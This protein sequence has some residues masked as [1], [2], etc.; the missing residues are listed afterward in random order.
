MPDHIKDATEFIGPVASRDGRRTLL[1]VPIPGGGMRVQVRDQF[2][3]YKREFATA[4]QALSYW[5]A[6]MGEKHD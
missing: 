4:W 3:T 6:E 5:D 1:A 2:G